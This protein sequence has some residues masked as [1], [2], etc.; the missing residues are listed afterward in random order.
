MGCVI[1]YRGRT[2]DLGYSR[3]EIRVFGQHRA[4]IPLSHGHATAIEAEP[5]RTT[6][7]Q[8]VSGH[9]VCRI[10]VAGE[11]K[12]GAKAGSEALQFEHSAV[13]QLPPQCYAFACGP[14]TGCLTVAAIALL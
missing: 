14:L 7:P 5:Q 1:A 4:A 8:F 10:D 2:I 12:H 3:I 13:G 11:I 9:R 6:W